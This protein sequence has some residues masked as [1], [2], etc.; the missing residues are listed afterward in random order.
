MT[1]AYA[2]YQATTVE[3]HPSLFPLPFQPTTSLSWTKGMNA[4]KQLY[5]FSKK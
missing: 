2:K 4:S 3:T 1:D 5:Y